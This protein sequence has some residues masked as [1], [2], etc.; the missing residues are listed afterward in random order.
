MKLAQRVRTL[1]LAAASCLATGAAAQASTWIVDINNGPGANFTQLTDAVANSQAGDV[2][3]VRPGTYTAPWQGTAINKGVTILGQGNVYF[4]TSSLEVAGVPAGEALVIVNLRPILWVVH[5]SPGSITIRESTAGGTVGLTAV[6]VNSCRDVRMQSM[7]G[8]IWEVSVNNSRMEITDCTLRGHDGQNSCCWGIAGGNGRSGLSIHAGSL[9]HLARSSSFGGRGGDTN[10]GPV[11]GGAGAPGIWL[12]QSELWIDGGGIASMKGATGGWGENCPWDGACGAGVYNDGGTLIRS[13][14]TLLPT[15]SPHCGAPGA[16]VALV[17]NATDQVLAADAPTLELGGSPV[18]GGVATFTVHAPPGS[19]V[20][21]NVGAIPQVLPTAGILVE[22]LVIK[23]R[24]FDLGTVPTSG[25]VVR[26]LNL[27]PALPPGYRL[28][29]QA[30]PVD[31][32]N[33]AV[34]RTASALLVVR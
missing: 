22:N 29:A 21:F 7:L 24:S 10:G 13:G 16:A 2:I 26:N 27:S 15:P 11:S 8:A 17:G 6:T 33:G 28:F 32:S 34:T 18:P 23:S 14:A 30:R 1:F 9:V 25:I 12:W 5:D 20:R 19:I 31:P 3:V 4:G